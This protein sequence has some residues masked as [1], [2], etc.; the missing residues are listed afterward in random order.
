MVNPLMLG[1]A[2]SA[3]PESYREVLWIVLE[4]NNVP[5]ANKK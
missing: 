5:G 2:V 3:R 1:I 4:K